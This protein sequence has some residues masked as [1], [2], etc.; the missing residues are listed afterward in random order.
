MGCCVL[1]TLARFDQPGQWL[2]A[3]AAQMRLWLKFVSSLLLGARGGRPDGPAGWS[4]GRRR[5]GLLVSRPLHRP[6]CAFLSH[7][8]R[9]RSYTSLSRSHIVFHR[10]LV[11]FPSSSSATRT[12]DWCNHGGRFRNVPAQK[13]WPEIHRRQESATVQEGRHQSQRIH[14]L[15]RIP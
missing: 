11:S 7:S 1:L 13:C 15:R 12:T 5:A 14:Y 8:P 3:G 10:S 4:S 2:G 6:V 9:T